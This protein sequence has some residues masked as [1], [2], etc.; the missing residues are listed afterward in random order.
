MSDKYTLVEGVDARQDFIH[1]GTMSVKNEVLGQTVCG[2][3]CSNKLGCNAFKMSTATMTNCDFYFAFTPERMIWATGNDN[4]FMNFGT[5]V[6]TFCNTL[7]G[8]LWW[9]FKATST[10][11]LLLQLVP[12]T[13]QLKL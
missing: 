5:G 8:F 3:G 12:H 6:F 10:S 13:S 7:M 9:L 4:V 11:K 1:I 2:A